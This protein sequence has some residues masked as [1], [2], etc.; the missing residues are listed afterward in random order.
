MEGLGFKCLGVGVGG[1]RAF[2][3]NGR[4]LGPGAL[5]AS[6]FHLNPDLQFSLWIVRWGSRYQRKPETAPLN[7]PFNG[8]ATHPALKAPLPGK[9]LGFRGLGV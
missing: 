1:F 6:N 5:R 8:T 4:D 3:F 2:G 9:I 7:E